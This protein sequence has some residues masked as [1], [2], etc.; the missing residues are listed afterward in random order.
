MNIREHSAKSLDYVDI[1]RRRGAQ[2]HAAMQRCPAA[3]DAEFAALWRRTSCPKRERIL[4]VPS[5]GG[6]LADALTRM[7]PAHGCTI[8]SLEFSDG[9]QEGAT[10]VEPDAPW[11]LASTGFDR[12][13]CLAAMHHV[14]KWSE[15]LSKMGQMLCIGGLLHLA[16]V[17]NDSGIS[18]FLDEFV[19]R[20]T[21][22]GH[23]GFYRDFATCVWPDG[24]EV[25][26]V[27]T[28]SCPW[29]F[30]SLEAC[31]LFCSELFGLEPSA[32]AGLE[33]ALRHDVGL[34][35]SAAGVEISWQL[36]YA[37]ARRIR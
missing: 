11:P 14:S 2:Y 13:I 28:C 5:G 22:T 17:P 1:F 7:D 30:S 26:P 23:K 4:D 29:H 31:L 16:D 35:E 25:L 8:T 12:L 9:F 6:Y 33:D 18:H 20:H 27:E 10:V 34:R 37:D 19:D 15:L 21:T 36:Q 32:T 3:R 24:L